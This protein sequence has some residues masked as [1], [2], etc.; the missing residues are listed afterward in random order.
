MPGVS[1]ATG[2]LGSQDGHDAS[3]IT[4]VV[5]GAC[6]VW[7]LTVALVCTIGVVQLYRPA[8]TALTQLSAD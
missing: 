2:A 7:Y 6:L 4:L 8:T 3:T 1:A 5:A